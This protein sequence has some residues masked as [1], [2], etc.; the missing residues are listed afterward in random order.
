[1]TVALGVVGLLVLLALRVP[2]AAALGVVAL[3]A[4]VVEDGIAN[5]PVIAAQ[6]MVNGVNSFVLIAA[7]FFMLAGEI[8][9]QGGLTA[10]DL[11]AGA[12][13]GR[14]D[15]GW[16][17]PGECRGQHVLLRHDGVGNFRRG[18]ARDDGDQGDER[19]RLRAQVF[20]RDHGCILR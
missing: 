3:A 15:S 8:M 11:P 16:A 1:M 12:C 20:R 9:N 19:G 14:L 6:S 2:V 10:E 4:V 18:G 5:A 13:A 17:R 7:P